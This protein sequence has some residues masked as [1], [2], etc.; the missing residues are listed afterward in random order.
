MRRI[1][2]VLEAM[3]SKKAVNKV[4]VF[5][6][7]WIERRRAAKAAAGADAA[8]KLEAAWRGA[9]QPTKEERQARAQRIQLMKAFEQHALDKGSWVH[10]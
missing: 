3:Q 9:A 10:A 4:H 2:D 8:T 7:R 1:Y 5:A 6:R